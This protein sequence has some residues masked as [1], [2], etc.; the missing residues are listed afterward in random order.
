VM[1]EESGEPLE[2]GLVRS[3]LAASVCGGSGD[4]EPV[5]ARD[6]H[7]SL[8]PVAVTAVERVV[9]AE[10]VR[11]VLRRRRD[12]VHRRTLRGPVRRQDRRTVEFYRRSS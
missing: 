5:Y 8:S 10:E 6:A 3:I 1:E 2:H 12:A 9:A 4:G 7:C 11:P